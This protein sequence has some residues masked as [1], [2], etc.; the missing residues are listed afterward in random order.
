MRPFCRAVLGVVRTPEWMR[1]G[2]PDLSHS[3][4]P[5]F[6]LRTVYGLVCAGAAVSP[7][8]YYCL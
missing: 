3:F 7:R 1:E 2:P 5:P 4:P 8:R 6:L